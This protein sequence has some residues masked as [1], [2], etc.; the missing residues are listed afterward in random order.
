MIGQQFP[1]FCNKINWHFDC[2]VSGALVCRFVLSHGFFVALRLVVIEYPPGPAFVPTGWEVL[3]AHCAFLSLRR[4][5]RFDFLFS[6]VG[7]VDVRLPTPRII[8][9]A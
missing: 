6:H 4:R 1:D 5:A 3:R 2:R 7:A 9:M 8:L